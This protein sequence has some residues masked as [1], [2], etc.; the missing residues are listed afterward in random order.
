MIKREYEK[1][2]DKMCKVIDITEYEFLHEQH[3]PIPYARAIVAEELYKM[4]FVWEAIGRC[5]GKSHSTLIVMCRKMNEIKESKQYPQVVT[6]YNKFHKSEE[7]VR[8]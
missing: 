8:D 5:I 3:H 1:L 6:M 7:D 2:R 4:G